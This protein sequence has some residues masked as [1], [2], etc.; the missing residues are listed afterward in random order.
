[1][2]RFAELRPFDKG[3]SGDKKYTAADETGG[4]FLLKICPEENRPGRQQLFAI[5]KKLESSGLSMQTPVEQFSCPEGFCTVYRWVEGEEL[6]SALPA[7][8]P[9]W[10]YGL[11]FRAG[12]MLKLIHSV[13]APDG[14]PAWEARFNAKIDRKIKMAK[15]CAE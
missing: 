14:L 9:D 6:R 11:G 10:Q 15:D 7:Y 2:K 4:K 1:M 3:W 8:S 5:L 12:E 13:P